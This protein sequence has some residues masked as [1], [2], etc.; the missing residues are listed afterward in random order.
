MTRKKKILLVDDH[1]IIRAGFSQLL[2]AEPDFEVCAQAGSAVEAMQAARKSNPD[3]AIVDISLEG[4]NGIEL[5]KSLQSF[6][7]DLPILVL[8]V[9]SESVYAQ[10]A[11]R[12]GAKGYVMKDTPTQEVLRAIRLVLKGELYFSGKM[13]DLL[14]KKLLP[15]PA[16]GEPSP[17]D[18]LTD[19]EL[20][21]F[22]LVGNGIKT[23]EIAKK[24]NLSVKTVETHRAHIK[25][26][27]GLKTSMDLVSCAVRWTNRPG[28]PQRNPPKSAK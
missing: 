9:H 6:H 26:K 21:V 2:E 8:S 7:P 24:L 20:E 3:L 18:A 25:E 16:K 4:C 17:I 27:L 12:A 1:P 14:V 15:S 22:E 28:T 23:T 11:L 13:N 19:R 5:I 10:R